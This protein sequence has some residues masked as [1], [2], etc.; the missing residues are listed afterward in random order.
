M[1]IYLLYYNILSLPSLKITQEFQLLLGFAIVFWDFKIQNSIGITVGSDNGDSGNRGSTVPSF[2]L[3][4]S[5]STAVK[6][7]AEWR[8]LWTLC[9]IFAWFTRAFLSSFND[10]DHLRAY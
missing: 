7:Q 9:R 2:Q 1:L 8:I 5:C 4:K 10:N 3:R 6:L